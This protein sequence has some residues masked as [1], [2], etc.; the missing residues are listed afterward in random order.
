MSPFTIVFWLWSIPLLIK[1]FT[2][3]KDAFV[4]RSLPDALFC[5][6][7]FAGLIPVKPE[8]E[9]KLF[10]WYF[11]VAPGGA[12]D[13]LVLLC[14]KRFIVD[15]LV[16]RWPRLFID[17]RTDGNSWAINIRIRPSSAPC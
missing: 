12:D 16:Q 15:S 6:P 8:S 13:E 9:K 14:Q 3:A 11:P 17:D 4:V 1:A 5:P 10:F 7:S 2:V